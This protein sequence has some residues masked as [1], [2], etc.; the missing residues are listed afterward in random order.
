VR[1]G[2][3]FSLFERTEGLIP[4]RHG[5]ENNPP[6]T[7]FLRVSTS[8]I[9]FHAFTDAARFVSGNP[10]PAQIRHD[11]SA[12]RRWDKALSSQSAI[13]LLPM[14]SVLWPKKTSWPC[15]RTKDNFSFPQKRSKSASNDQRDYFSGIRYELIVENGQFSI[16]FPE[17]INCHKTVH[18]EC[19]RSFVQRP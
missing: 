2:T 14:W 3:I 13:P 10:T 1:A 9:E 18:A 5:I 16:H 6:N 8:S 15:M 19:L 7:S 11:Q 4:S 12:A 17:K